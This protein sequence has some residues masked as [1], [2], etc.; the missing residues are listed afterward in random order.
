MRNKI[1][2]KECGTVFWMYPKSLRAYSY[3]KLWAVSQL[4]AFVR[5]PSHGVKV[6]RAGKQVFYI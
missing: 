4:N 6:L 2:G 5:A 1:Y 3:W